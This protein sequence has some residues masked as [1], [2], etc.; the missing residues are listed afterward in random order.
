MA[1]KLVSA[2]IVPARRVGVMAILGWGSK[3]K[4]P[5][6]TSAPKLSNK[7]EKSPRAASG[8]ENSRSDTANAVGAGAQLSYA[9]FRMS[10]FDGMKEAVFIPH[11]K[12]SD[13]KVM[14]KVFSAL[15]MRTPNLLIVNHSSAFHPLRVLDD[16]EINHP[17]LQGLCGDEMSVSQKADTIR[18]VLGVKLK[19]VVH[20]MLAA[21][22]QTQ[23]ATYSADTMSGTFELLASMCLASGASVKSIC[24]IDMNDQAYAN[25]WTKRIFAALWQGRVQLDE[26]SVNAFGEPLEIDGA[27][28]GKI[29]MDE[30]FEANAGNV[31]G[32]PK[33]EYYSLPDPGKERHPWTFWPW[34]DGDLFLIA[35]RGIG[36]NLD[37]ESVHG[38]QVDPFP[39]ITVIAP[40]G[41]VFVGGKT[42]LMKEKFLGAVHLAT[43]SAIINHTGGLASLCS[44]MVLA[45]SAV[46]Q[47]DV[48]T[49]KK[50][51]KHEC[52]SQARQGLPLADRLDMISASSLLA[53]AKSSSYVDDSSWPGGQFTVADVMQILDLARARPQVFTQT[54]RVIDPL[55]N[56]AEECLEIFSSCMSSTY[57]GVL[58]LGASGAQLEVVL[59]AWKIYQAIQQKASDLQ[60]KLAALTYVAALAAWTATLLAVLVSELEN[61]GPHPGEGQSLCLLAREGTVRGIKAAMVVAPILAGLFQTMLS[62]FQYRDKWAATTTAAA[63]IVKH[64]YLFRGAVACYS[65]GEAAMQEGEGEKDTDEEQLSSAAK[66]R[67]VRMKFIKTVTSIYSATSANLR[68]DFLQSQARGSQKLEPQNLPVYVLQKLYNA[69]CPASKQQKQADSSDCSLCQCLTRQT[70]KPQPARHLTVQVGDPDCEEDLEVQ[71]L[72]NATENSAMVPVDP[73]DPWEGMDDCLAPLTAETYFASRV[74]KLLEKLDSDLPSLSWEQS[75]GSFGLLLCSFAASVLGA[76]HRSIWIPVILG[77]AALLNVIMNFRASGVRLTA[78]NK[79]LAALR[80]LEMQ[81]RGMSSMDRRTP[82][83]K[84][85]LIEKTEQHAL[86]VIRTWAGSSPLSFDVQE[87]D[88][89]KEDDASQASKQ[90]GKKTH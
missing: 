44:E 28:M 48:R 62:Q 88:A 89:V 45:L 26:A 61:C 67:L 8:N 2:A 65:A 41:K 13:P 24:A 20:A 11:H 25:K 12:C 36:G 16:H 49:L 17:E 7:V 15:K 68:D 5:T 10:G 18:E 32:L 63:E 27:W 43:P 42:A 70:A 58:E 4:P 75:C 76:F 83:F 29:R 77:F 71:F 35:Y 38:L 53:F 72:D 86:E 50:L 51:A 21:A 82:D 60:F 74:A 34:P 37:T 47:D 64:I 79:A 31:R 40:P 23:S 66:A 9:R 57:T 52:K 73:D 81:Y 84:R 46:I 19:A 3:N 69:D 56:T 85:L 30:V 1:Q 59:E 54:I 55:A 90:K 39:D 6:E 33:P 80:S 78:T 22:E 87:S 14:P